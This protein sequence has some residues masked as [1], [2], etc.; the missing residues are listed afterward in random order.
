MVTVKTLF[1][2]SFDIDGMMG[3]SARTYYPQA[4]KQFL[5]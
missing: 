2:V 3:R 1:F 4:M 5:K